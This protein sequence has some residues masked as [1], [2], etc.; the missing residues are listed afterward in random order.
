M[1]LSVCSCNVTNNAQEKQK[2]KNS[3]KQTN[4]QTS[5]QHSLDSLLWV[6]LLPFLLL[7]FFLDFDFDRSRLPPSPSSSP[8]PSP[9]RDAAPSSPSMDASS[10][11]RFPPILAKSSAWKS[12]V[13]GWTNK[14]TNKQTLHTYN[15]HTHNVIQWNL[16]MHLNTVACNH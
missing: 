16:G 15:V 7:F 11:G 5:K 2:E 13:G 14:Q 9:P 10:A 12:V 1:F 6:R 4:Q 3:N 8:S